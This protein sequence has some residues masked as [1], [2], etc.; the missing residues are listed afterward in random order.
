MEFFA[1]LKLLSRGGVDVLEEKRITH[2]FL[3]FSFIQ[4]GSPGLL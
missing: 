1:S 2:P 4:R 3:I